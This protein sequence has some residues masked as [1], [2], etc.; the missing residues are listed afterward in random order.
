MGA[1]L[2][3]AASSASKEALDGESGRFLDL[4][5]SSGN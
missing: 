5:R 1:W 3:L 4:L 2:R